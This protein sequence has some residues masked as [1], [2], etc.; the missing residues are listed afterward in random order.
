VI[1]KLRA[2]RQEL[3]DA[4]W[5][6]APRGASGGIYAAAGWSKTALSAGDEWNRP[7]R[8]RPKA[9]SAAPKQR[10]ELAL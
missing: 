5:R 9:Q 3:P 10:W 6:P 4:A 2:Q 7:G 1:D 8:S